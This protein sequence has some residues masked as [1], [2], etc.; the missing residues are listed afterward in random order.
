VNSRL[1][2]ES[3]SD[4]PGKDWAL[5]HHSVRST[6]RDTTNRD[7]QKAKSVVFLNAPWLALSIYMYIAGDPI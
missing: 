7:A 2:Q 1:I 3:T 6:S 5:M 4:A